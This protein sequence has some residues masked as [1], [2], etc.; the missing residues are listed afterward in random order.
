MQ[1]PNC[2]GLTLMGSTQLGPGQEDKH[3]GEEAVQFQR[4]QYVTVILDNADWTQRWWFIHVIH[5]VYST[6]VARK[7]LGS[8]GRLPNILMRQSSLA[9]WTMLHSHLQQNSG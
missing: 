7:L 3:F 4:G 8:L 5:E 9:V 2:G 6:A 1:L